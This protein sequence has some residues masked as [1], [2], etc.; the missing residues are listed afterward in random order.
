[1]ARSDLA[2]MLSCTIHV[3]ARKIAVRDYISPL[4]GEI[5]NL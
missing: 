1:M 4:A 3:A 2:E 5:R